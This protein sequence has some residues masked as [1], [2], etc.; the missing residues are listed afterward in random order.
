MRRILLLR[1]KDPDGSWLQRLLCRLFWHVLT[2]GPDDATYV[3]HPATDEL[4]GVVCE[5]CGAL[6]GRRS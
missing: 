4:L 1:H 2:T 6:L 3:R 5:R